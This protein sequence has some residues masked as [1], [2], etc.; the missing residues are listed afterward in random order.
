MTFEGNWSHFFSCGVKPPTSDVNRA[1]A[2][3]LVAQID[4]P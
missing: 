2:L 1:R 3:G 4:I